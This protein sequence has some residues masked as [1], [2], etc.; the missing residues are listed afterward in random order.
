MHRAGTGFP[1]LL[2]ARHDLPLTSVNKLQVRVQVKNID[3][4]VYVEM[5]G[6]NGIALVIEDKVHA[7]SYNELDNYLALVGGI[8][9]R[10]ANGHFQPAL[11]PEDEQITPYVS[12]S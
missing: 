1:R 3:V 7:G 10:P 12:I 2:L 8:C 11:R 9:F 6:A 4:L 5:K